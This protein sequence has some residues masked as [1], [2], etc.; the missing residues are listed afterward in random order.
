MSPA[1]STNAV[2]TIA[3]IKSSHRKGADPSSPSGQKADREVEN[4]IAAIRASALRALA[5]EISIELPKART[6]AGASQMTFAIDALATSA[7]ELDPLG[8]KMDILN[9]ITRT[10]KGT[11]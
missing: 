3:A 6:P 11:P 4:F 7:D 9:K 8:K 2:P 10:H 5:K 1:P